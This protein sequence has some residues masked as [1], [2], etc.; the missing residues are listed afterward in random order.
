[1]IS[2]YIHK[3]TIYFCLVRMAV[4]KCVSSNRYNEVYATINID[5]V[6]K[7]TVKAMITSKYR[8]TIELLAV[9]VLLRHL[10][11]SITQC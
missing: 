1:M 5:G 3:V 10:Q 2:Q 9:K 7:V 4:Y 11:I 6:T 8:Y